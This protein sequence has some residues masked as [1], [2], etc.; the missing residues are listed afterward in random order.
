MRKAKHVQESKKNKFIIVILIIILIVLILAGGFFIWSKLNNKKDNKKETNNE[1]TSNE[2]ETTDVDGNKD[3]TAKKDEIID[4]SDIPDKIAGYD[5]LGKIVIDK[6]GIQQN[7]L[8][9]TTDDSL[10]HGVTKFW[11][12]NINQPGNMSITGHNY[13]GI[14]ADLRNLEIGDTFYIV[15][16][17]GRKVTYTVTEKISKVAPN[18]MSHIEQDGYDKRK[19][20]IITCDPGARTRLIVKGESKLEGEE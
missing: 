4:T 5:V 12:S 14:F 17:D 11:G 16:K 18:D 10:N 13:K 1:E 7:I 20:T 8:S 15:S 2:T 6:I 19:V 9:E 3:N